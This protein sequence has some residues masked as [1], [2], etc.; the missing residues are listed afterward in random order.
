[1]KWSQKT[2]PLVYDEAQKYFV[3]SIEEISLNTVY[4]FFKYLMVQTN[5]KLAESNLLN[6][7]NNLRIAQTK[8][9]LGKNFG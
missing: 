5:Y 6:S 1:M 4:R 7:R 9:D 3:Q 8:K 2:E